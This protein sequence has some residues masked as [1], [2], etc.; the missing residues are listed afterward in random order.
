MQ[1]SEGK[2][3]FFS[4]RWLRQ[5][6]AGRFSF[7]DTFFAGMFGPAFVFIPVG[8]VIAG[9]L[10]AVAS[11][12]MEVAIAGMTVLYALYFSATL[13]AIFKTGLAA[14][15]I[16]GWRWTGILL[17]VASTAGLW[18]AAYKFMVAL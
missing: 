16:G 9:F 10:A 2:P 8:V 18:W 3:R 6:W 14:N 17:A 13:P 4:G 12:A 7:G 15:D 5:L 1:R 11:G